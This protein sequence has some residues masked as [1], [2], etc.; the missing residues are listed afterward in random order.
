MPYYHKILLVC[1]SGHR[2]HCKGG[3]VLTALA[4]TSLQLVIFCTVGGGGLT[5]VTAAS[6]QNFITSSDIGI[7]V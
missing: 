1:V 2:L 4:G 7:S 6:S 3:G 5:A